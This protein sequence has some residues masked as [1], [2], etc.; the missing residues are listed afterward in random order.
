MHTVIIF[1]NTK[2]FRLN[3]TDILPCL[4]QDR[5]ILPDHP[6]KCAVIIDILRSL[7]PETIISYLNQALNVSIEQHPK[8]II[9][10]YTTKYN[11][12]DKY[13]AKVN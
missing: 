13:A 9:N 10:V 11:S 4:R 7:T 1:L 2:S 6:T 5:Y 3:W 8:Y 12:L